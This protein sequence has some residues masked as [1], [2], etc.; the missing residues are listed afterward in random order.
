M[1]TIYKHGIY[2]EAE[3]SGLTSASRSLG[4]I[5]AYIGTL[6]IQR[7]NENGEAGFD[8]SPYI[9]KPILISSYRDVTK[10]H[11]DS[12]DWATY[13]L[14][15]AIH[16]HFRNDNEVAAPIILVNVLDPSD[17]SEATTETVVL[18][19]E[20]T[21]K[22][23]YIEDE[24]ASLDGMAITVS[25][26]QLNDG[27]F[28]LS[29]ADNAIKITITK[30]ISASSVEATYKKIAFAKDDVTADIFNEALYSLDMSEMLTGYIPNI[31]AAPGFSC[32][33]ALHTKM[34]QYAIDKIAMKWNLIVCSDIPCGSDVNTIAKAKE[35]KKTNE[36]N[37]KLDKVC[38][39]KVIKGTKVY[40]LSTIAAYTMQLTDLNNDDVPNVSPSNKAINADGVVLDDGTTFFMREYEANELNE[41]GITTVNIVQRQLRLWGAHMANYDFTKL[42]SISFEDRSD[43][44]IRM[45]LYLANML[46]YEYIDNID[47]PVS[48]KDID[49]IKNSVQQRLNSL[50]NE[51]KLLFATIDFDDEY[52]TDEDIANG[53]F[54]FDIAYTL[55][56]NSKSITFKMRYTNT[57]LTILTSGGE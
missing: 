24:L 15:E 11:L 37:N 54:T 13:T 21:S 28:S 39:P 6:P 42:S 4:T 29:Y 46:Q 32:I 43:S 57:G 2:A 18:N 25:G 56:P 33:P 31:I 8:Y 41:V 44:G 3:D 38:Y 50:V 51:G 16:A 10:L 30:E 52:N 45:A 27:D 7:V 40:N 36:Y 19:R 23:G 17:L 26:E 34:V 35:W 1:S 22:V 53:D 12:D 5:P 48:R 9:K 47:V 55:A 20:G 14:C 49:G